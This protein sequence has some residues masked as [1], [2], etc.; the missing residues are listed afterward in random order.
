MD[1]VTKIEE[2]GSPAENLKILAGISKSLGIF[3]LIKKELKDP[4]TIFIKSL[5]ILEYPFIILARKFLVKIFEV[6]FQ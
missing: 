2:K 1:F 4:G 6:C 5:R 3:N